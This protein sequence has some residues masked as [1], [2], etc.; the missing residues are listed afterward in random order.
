MDGKAPSEQASAVVMALT[1][2]LADREDLWASEAALQEA[3]FP[4]AE[5]QE[6]RNAAMDKM[7]KSFIALALALDALNPRT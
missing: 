3:A 4:T 1:I 2:Y 6:Q 5:M 7:E